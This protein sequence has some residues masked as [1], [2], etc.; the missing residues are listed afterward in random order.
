MSSHSILHLVLSVPC[1]NTYIAAHHVKVM[2]QQSN[3]VVPEYQVEDL[4]HCCLPRYFLKHYTL[5]H[6][7]A[8]GSS[9]DYNPYCT[10]A[11]SLLS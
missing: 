11:M 1:V 3:V 7:T 4:A 5:T 2:S 8:N 10:N 9:P 6:H